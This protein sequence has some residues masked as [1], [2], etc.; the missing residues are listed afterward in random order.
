MMAYIVNIQRSVPNRIDA[1]EQA[2]TVSLT[3]SMQAELLQVL[4]SSGTHPC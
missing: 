4:A 3:G 2:R 1:T